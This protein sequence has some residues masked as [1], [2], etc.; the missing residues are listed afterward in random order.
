MA[1]GTVKKKAPAKKTAAKKTA[2]K[3]KRGGKATKRTG[4]SGG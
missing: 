1:K 4:S 2:T 3:A